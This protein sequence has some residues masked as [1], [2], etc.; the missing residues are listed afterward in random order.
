MQTLERQKII[1]VLPTEHAQNQIEHK[2]GTHQNEGNKVDPGPFITYGIINL[3]DISGSA[4]NI[5]FC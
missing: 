4:T 1:V 3:K 2:E 5:V